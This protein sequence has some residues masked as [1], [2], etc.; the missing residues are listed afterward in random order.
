MSS[1]FAGG[2]PLQKSR[3]FTK[4]LG[5]FQ[6]LVNDEH[7]PRTADGS[8]RGFDRAID[9]FPIVVPLGCL[10]HSVPLVFCGILCYKKVHP[11]FVAIRAIIVNRASGDV[12]FRPRHEHEQRQARI[13]PEKKQVEDRPERCGHAVDRP[14]KWSLSV[15]SASWM[16]RATGPRWR[17][18]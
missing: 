4:A 14:P 15:C 16:R 1:R 18:N 7:H 2:D 10:R 8:N 3:E 6:Q 11:C 5:A 17:Q 13:M 12:D 9:G